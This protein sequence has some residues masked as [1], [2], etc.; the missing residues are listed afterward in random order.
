MCVYKV[1]V[2]CVDRMQIPTQIQ[3]GSVISCYVQ[4]EEGQWLW[5]ACGKHE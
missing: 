4:M 2:S 5:R 3:S 1:G